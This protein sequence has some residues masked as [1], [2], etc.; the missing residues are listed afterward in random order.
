M[1]QATVQ[2]FAN[3]RKFQVRIALKLYCFLLLY[4]NTKTVPRINNA[5][6]KGI[7]A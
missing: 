1:T 3:F 4:F 7:Y 6:R 2:G 5:T